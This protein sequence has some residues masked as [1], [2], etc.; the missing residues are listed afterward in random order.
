MLCCLWLYCP[1]K[2]HICDLSSFCSMYLGVSLL[3]STFLQ[4]GFLHLLNRVYHRLPCAGSFVFNGMIGTPLYALRFP[5]LSI[6][7]AVCTKLC[8]SSLLQVTS[9]AKFIYG[10]LFSKIIHLAF[11]SGILQHFSN[12]QLIKRLPDVWAVWIGPFSI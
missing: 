2:H 8:T 9:P 1:N 4:R 7:W 12:P 5:S 3:G 6:Q 10:L 11:L